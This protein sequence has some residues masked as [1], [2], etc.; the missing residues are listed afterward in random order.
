MNALRA[1]ILMF[2]WCPSGELNELESI[3]DRYVELGP[4]ALQ[5][6][7]F[8]LTSAEGAFREYAARIV[9]GY[10]GDALQDWLRGEELAA[11]LVSTSDIASYRVTDRNPGLLLELLRSIARLHTNPQT[12]YFS[13]HGTVNELSFDRNLSSTLSFADFA[14]ALG[15]LRLD[16][17]TLVL[18]CCYGLNE[19]SAL[20]AQLPSQILE[21][22][23]FTGEPLASDVASLMLGVLIDDSSRFALASGANRQHFGEGVPGRE[24][25]ETAIRLGAVIDTL[26]D[27]FS[28]NPTA[29][30]R[31][32]GGVGVRWLKRVEYEGHSVWQGRTIPLRN[33]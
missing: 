2:Q 5:P 15:E 4:S 27:A 16:S 24:A 32:S 31:G 20:L 33:R 1:P 8:R 10:P 30:V 22:Y 14:G 28:A 23:A 13:C 11:R 21:V 26:L 29:H 18:G 12:L 6:E 3:E 7:L 9:A 17:V 19:Q 25:E